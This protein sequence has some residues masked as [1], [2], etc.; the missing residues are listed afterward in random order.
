MNKIINYI[1][2]FLLLLIPITESLAKNTTTNNQKPPIY[3]I[4]NLSDGAPIQSLN[5]NKKHSI[6]SLTKLMTAYIFIENYPNIKNCTIEITDLDA[7]PIKHTQTQLDKNSKIDCLSAI[8]IM[9]TISDN[10]IASSLSRNLPGISHKDFIGLMNNKAREWGMKNTIYY[11]ST[12]LSY[13][14]KSTANDLI[15]LTRHLSNNDL[16]TEL[17]SKKE[18]YFQ[19]NNKIIH[20][21]NSN[22]LIREMN[23]S[24]LLSKTGHIK[25]S[26][27]NL[28][29]IPKEKCNNQNIGVIILGANSS[30]ARSNFANNILLSN[31]CHKY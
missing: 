20:F 28:I 7:D 22:R 16:I 18:V 10:W 5:P 8:E 13:N 24:A 12:G 2:F 31:S 30:I 17:S 15:I 27:Y 26:G 1:M 19:Q 3:E 14:N 29:F 11:D 21:K 6:A 4:F 9:L 25:E 23:F